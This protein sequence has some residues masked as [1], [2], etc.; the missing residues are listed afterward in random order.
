MFVDGHASR[1]ERHSLR[2]LVSPPG[3]SWRIYGAGREQCY[4]GRAMTTPAPLTDEP[5]SA[6][7]LAVGLPRAVLVRVVLICAASVASVVVT[8]LS[9]FAAVAALLGFVSLP[10]EPVRAVRVAKLALI[11]GGLC[12]TFGVF[13][14]LVLEAVP[15]M[16]EGGTTATEQ[17]VVSRLR[18]ILFAEDA[19]RRNTFVDPDGDHVG[20]AE[21]LGEMTGEIGLRGSA[22]MATPVLQNYPKLVDTRLGPAADVGG[23]LVIVCLPKKGGGFT[24]RPSDAVDDERAERSFYAYAWPTERGRGLDTAYFLDEHER[25]L[26]ADSSETEP[27]RL[28]GVDA[29]PACDDVAAVATAADWRV[30]RNKQPR[31]TLP[32]ETR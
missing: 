13:R 5:D 26:L 31:R 4:D 12:A 8:K 28:I 9:L 23:Y 11:V 22:P 3:I 16:V 1:R 6:A 17:R 21:F 7:P 19:L 25:I 2:R 14:F 29:P 18:E 20:S 15:G 24:A 32:F 10:S 27:R 30:W